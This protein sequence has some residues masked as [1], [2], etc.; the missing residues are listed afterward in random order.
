MNY[1]PMYN[2]QKGNAKRRGI[3]W[4]LT[5]E[6]W[7][8]IWQE[9]GRLGERGPRLGCYVM[10]RY[11]DKG[12]YKVGNVRIVTSSE[13]HREAHSIRQVAT[14]CR[15]TAPETGPNFCDD[16]LDMMDPLELLE[17]IEIGLDRVF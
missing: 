6:E 2:I 10:A 4:E 8:R 7:L 17:K 11:G 5:Y 9:S 1:R 14:G 3:P 12:P 15:R 16:R 13:N